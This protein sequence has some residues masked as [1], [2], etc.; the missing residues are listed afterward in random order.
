MTEIISSSREDLELDA[1]SMSVFEDG[2]CW[3]VAL[4]DWEIALTLSSLRYAHWRKRWRDLGDYT[5]AEIEARITELEHSFMSG[6]RLADLIKTQRMLV[7]AITGTSVDLDSDLPTGEIDYSDYGLAAA[8]RYD[9]EG[10]AQIVSEMQAGQA[11]SRITLKQY[12]EAFESDDKV[13]YSPI[14]GM[15]GALS[16]ILPDALQEHYLIEDPPLFTTNLI[17][18]LIKNVNSIFQSGILAVTAGAQTG[19]AGADAIKT[20]ANSLDTVF[21]GISAG[22]LSFSAIAD[23]IEL[24]TSGQTPPA[25]ENPALRAQVRVLND[26]FVTQGAVNVNCAP[27]VNVNC[28]GGCGGQPMTDTNTNIT[29][30]ND[31]PEVEQPDPE[32]D[33]PPGFESW[34][35][36]Y[37]YRCQAANW[38]YDQYVGTLRNWG[39]FEGVVGIITLALIIGVMLLAVPPLGLA[40]VCGAIAALAATDIALFALFVAI[41]DGLDAQKEDLVCGLYNATTTSEAIAALTD[42]SDTIID[43]LETTEGLKAHF[44]N[45]CSNLLAN[46]N[47]KVLFEKA[48]TLDGYEGSVGCEVCGPDCQ[49]YQIWG[50]DFVDDGEMFNA[51]GYNYGQGYAFAVSSQPQWAT[52]CTC[53][54]IVSVEIVTGIYGNYGG[55]P[56]YWFIFWLE[57]EQEQNQNFYTDNDFISWLSSHPSAIVTRIGAAYSTIN[58]PEVNVT[59]E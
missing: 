22:A 3:L 45:A 47:V 44:K 13:Q 2:D 41:A 57:N 51:N 4:D 40:V 58:N 50:E 11:D 49:W 10:I 46:N 36:Y 1:G 18:S 20:V 15:L 53:G 14:Y 37:T 30:F 55:Q 31:G 39:S 26:V 27:D 9:G 17:D 29:D 21:A 35:A 8:L 59:Y 23:M 7:A 33:P 16:D 6:C 38:L 34:G 52:P 54:F 5:W 28:G 25:D 32:G 43:G 42:A 24:F 12:F 48:P 56:C 19:E